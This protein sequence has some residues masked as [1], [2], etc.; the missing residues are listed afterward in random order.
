MSDSI[1]IC[2]QPFAAVTDAMGRESTS[3]TIDDGSTVSDAWNALVQSY[4]D[5]VALQ[6]TIAFAC[7]DRIVNRQTTLSD[8]DT[9]ALL[10][11]VSGG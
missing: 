1:T 6:D 8:G 10:P 11:P 7:N 3:I 2:I 5:L 9:L 4:P